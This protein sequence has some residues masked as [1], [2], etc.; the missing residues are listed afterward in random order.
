[1]VTRVSVLFSEPK[2]PQF[3]LK[4]DVRLQKLAVSVLFSEP[5]IPQLGFFVDRVVVST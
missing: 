4:R 3:V 1:M 5:K 2:I